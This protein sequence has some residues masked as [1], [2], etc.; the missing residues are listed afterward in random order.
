MEETIEEFACDL[1]KEFNKNEDDN[2]YWLSMDSARLIV[3]GLI[4]K[5]YK[6]ESDTAREILTEIDDLTL[7]IVDGSNEFEK[8]YFQAIADMKTAIKDLLKEKYG[9][10][11]GE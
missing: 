11:L 10:D 8:G 5:G 6:K 3:K 1:C 7:C 2:Y 9:V 4:A